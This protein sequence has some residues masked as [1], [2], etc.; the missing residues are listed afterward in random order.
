[1]GAAEFARTVSKVGYLLKSYAKSFFSYCKTKYKTMP[2]YFKRIF[3]M[4]IKDFCSL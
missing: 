2:A 3:G 1:M 4:N